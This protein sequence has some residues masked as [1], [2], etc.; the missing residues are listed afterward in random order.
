MKTP[1]CPVAMKINAAR[2]KRKA[3]AAKRIVAKALK[4][5]PK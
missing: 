4:N 1:K 5:S 3:I 2:D